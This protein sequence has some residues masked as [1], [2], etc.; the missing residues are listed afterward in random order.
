MILIKDLS[1]EDLLS[2]C[3]IL[4]QEVFF[5]LG[6]NINEED[7]AAW[8]VYLAK[9]LKRYFANLYIEDIKTSFDIGLRETDLFHFSVKTYMKWIKTHRNLIWKN[10]DI[11]EKYKDKRLNYRSEIKLLTNK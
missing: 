6:Q 4:I 10:E 11:N 3:A 7:L 1:K 5:Q 8:S 9:D 2:K